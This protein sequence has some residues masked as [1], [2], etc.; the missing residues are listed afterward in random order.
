[1]DQ[2]FADESIVFVVLLDSSRLKVQHFICQRSIRKE[3][4]IFSINYMNSNELV[5]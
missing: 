4:D 3:I 1:M 2:F 5:Y